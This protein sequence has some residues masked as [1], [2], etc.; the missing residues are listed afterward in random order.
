MSI[1][2]VTPSPAPAPAPAETAKRAKPPRGQGSGRRG[3]ARPRPPMIDLAQPGHL[4]VGNVMALLGIGSSTTFYKRLADGRIPLPD[5]R[6][7]RPYWFTQTIRDFLHPPLDEAG[8]PV[9]AVGVKKDGGA[10]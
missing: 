8:L 3:G 1:S 7:P 9:L 5:G 4:S 6:N 10:K 2:F